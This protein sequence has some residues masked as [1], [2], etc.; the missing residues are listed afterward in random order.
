MK[1]VLA[2]IIECLK[3]PIEPHTQPYKVA[4][5]NN[6]F[7]LVNQCCL[8]FLSCGVYSNSIWYDVIPMKVSHIILSHPWLYDLDVHHCGKENTYNFIFKTKRLCWNQWLLLNWKKYRIQKSTKVV[9][10]MKSSLHILTK[11]KFQHESMEN[12]VMYAL[13]MKEV[14]MKNAGNIS[15]IPKKVFEL[16]NNFSDIALAYLPSELLPFRNIQHSIDFMSGS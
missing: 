6:M 14:G 3:V 11:K 2:S 13:V 7:I 1:V 10:G 16:P 4:W 5:I 12:G 8:V 9:E 15:S